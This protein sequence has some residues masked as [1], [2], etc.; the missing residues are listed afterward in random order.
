MNAPISMDSIVSAAPDQLSCALADESAILN[1][2][3]SV[4]YGLDPVGTR[5]WNLLR[6]AI[7]VAELRDKLMEEYDVEADQ[8][9]RDLLNLLE[10]M[11]NEGLIRVHGSEPG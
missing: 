10:T 7:S 3:S 11:R 4:Y 2:K 5:V 8:C 6:Q 9:E 1:L